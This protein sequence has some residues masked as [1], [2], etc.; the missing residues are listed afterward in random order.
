MAV[1]VTIESQA[2]VEICPERNGSSVIV[3]NRSPCFKFLA[4]RVVGDRRP[5][6]RVDAS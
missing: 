3:L 1:R 2:G 5:R 4:P 6:L